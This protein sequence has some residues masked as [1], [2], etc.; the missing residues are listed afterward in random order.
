MT[1]SFRD[2]QTVQLK[3]P[4][5]PQYV[6]AQFVCASQKALDFNKKR[7]HWV[8]V[9]SGFKYVWSMDPCLVKQDVHIDGKERVQMWTI[10]KL[11]PTQTPA[12]DRLAI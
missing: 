11:H 12:P 8:S 6:S 3:I 10:G 4:Q 1:I 2:L 9:V 7:L 5:M